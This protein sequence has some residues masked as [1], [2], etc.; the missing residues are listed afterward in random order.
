MQIVDLIMLIA[1]TILL[2]M[3]FI[4]IP[5]LEQ[6]DLFETSTPH[7]RRGVASRIGEVIFG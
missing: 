2:I 7:R 4:S 5:L 6:F 3:V 1:G